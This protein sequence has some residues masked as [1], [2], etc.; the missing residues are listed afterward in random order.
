MKHQKWNSLITY[1]QTQKTDKETVCVHDI[2][3]HTMLSASEV[4]KEAR[5]GHLSVQLTTM[6]CDVITYFDHIRQ[7]WSSVDILYGDS[8]TIHMTVENVVDD[9]PIT[10]YD[11]CK[12][13]ETHD[14]LAWAPESTDASEWSFLIYGSQIHQLLNT[15]Q[16]MNEHWWSFER[17]AHHTHDYSTILSIRIYPCAFSKD[18]M[19]DMGLLGNRKNTHAVASPNDSALPTSL[20]VPLCTENTVSLRQQQDADYYA[21]LAA[22]QLKSRESS[23][24]SL[25]PRDKQMSLEKSQQ[26]ISQ[27]HQSTDD[28]GQ[29]DDKPLNREQL[30]KARC[31]F[32]DA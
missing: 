8:D 7:Q 21:S 31:A 19:R 24:T 20:A 23:L 14:S 29:H 15:T 30:R 32:Y 16:C 11:I 27:N 6:S 13:I 4:W 22:D 17:F 1:L 3:T 25:T 18:I 2:V 9:T 5:L 28:I 10:M 12:H 26:S